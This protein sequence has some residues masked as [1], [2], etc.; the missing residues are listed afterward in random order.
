MGGRNFGSMNLGGGGLNIS[1]L[2]KSLDLQQLIHSQHF[3]V[4]VKIYQI[5]LKRSM[6]ISA[7]IFAV[8]LR[9]FYSSYGNL[10]IITFTA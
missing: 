9:Y 2:S 3:E 8:L 6:V 4:E 5:V 10:L 7:D 1:D